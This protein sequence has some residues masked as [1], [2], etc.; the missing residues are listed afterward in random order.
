MGKACYKTQSVKTLD[1]VSK[2]CQNSTLCKSKLQT[3]GSFIVEQFQSDNHCNKDS[4]IVHVKQTNQKNKL[5]D[6]KSL[7][8]ETDFLSSVEKTCK[9]RKK[10]KKECLISVKV[11]IAPA[12][13]KAYHYYTDPQIADFVMDQLE[14]NGFTKAR[15]VEAETNAILA[16]PELNPPNIAKQLGYKHEVI[17]LTKDERVKVSFKDGEIEVAKSMR[18]SDVII[19]I[20]KPKNH[21]LMKF[22]ASL[23]NMY[24]SIPDLNK[25]I[26]FHHKKSGLNVQEATVAVNH[27]TPVDIIIAD[28][29]DSVDGNEVSYFNEEIEENKFQHYPSNRIILG[30]NPL[31]VDKYIARKMGYND[32]DSPILTEE[33]KFV[34]EKEF[35]S[36]FVKGDNIKPFTDWRKIGKGL[37][38]KAK[39]QDY[40]PVND[41]MVA[42]GI[43]NYKFPII[44][45]H[46]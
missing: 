25:Y 13:Q 36:D 30:T 41:S 9:N 42:W 21:D 11:N 17:D 10:N 37:N 5:N 44:E 31:M 4:R 15:L 19:N 40:I 2:L 6:L 34:G 45:D 33:E 1:E 26:L 16:H 8:N 24:G 23:K 12:S 28:W 29:V 43:R 7:L 46:K 39:L 20:P 14:K 32:K 3:D 38:T 18:D 22:T 35:K 27:I